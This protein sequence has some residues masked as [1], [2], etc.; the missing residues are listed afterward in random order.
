MGTFFETDT[1]PSAELFKAALALD[2]INTSAI[3]A[4]SLRCL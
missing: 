3:R 4:N 1:I 2:G